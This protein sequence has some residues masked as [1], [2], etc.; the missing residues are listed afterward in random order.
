MKYGISMGLGIILWGT[1]LVA[2]G[3]QTQEMPISE[4]IK[5]NRQIVKL[6]SEEIS[7]TLPQKVD[8]YTVLQKVIGK[9]TTLNYVFEINTGAKS[10]ETVKHED[11]TRMQKAVTKGICRSSKRF[12]DAEINITYLYKSAVSKAVL[13]QFDVSKDDCMKSTYNQ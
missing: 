7:K 12:L 9:D 3:L 1:M 6:A 11:R 2:E 13:F 5:Q 8:N 4:L 10:D